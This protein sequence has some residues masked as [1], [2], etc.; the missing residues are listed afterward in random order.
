MGVQAFL[1]AWSQACQTKGGVLQIPQGNYS[2]SGADFQGPCNGQ[3]SVFLNGTLKASSDPTLPLDHWIQ[4]GNVDN[5]RIYGKGVLDGNG[6]MSW[7]KCS[8]L[9]KC[10]LP[11]TVRLLVELMEMESCLIPVI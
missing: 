7:G 3:T 10:K 8:D 11:P 2:L 6:A 5:L 1:K 9:Q 4:F